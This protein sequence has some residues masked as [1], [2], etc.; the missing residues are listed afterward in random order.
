MSLPGCV[1]EHLHGFAQMDSN[2]HAPKRFGNET[3]AH[4]GVPI[5]CSHVPFSWRSRAP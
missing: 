2:G 4:H 1:A 5:P 3:G